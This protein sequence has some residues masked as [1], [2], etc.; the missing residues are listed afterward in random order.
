MSGLEAIR[1]F[2]EQPGFSFTLED[3]HAALSGE[4]GITLHDIQGYL[5]DS[6]HLFY[7][8]QLNRWIRRN[9]FFQDTEFLI[10]PTPEELKQGILIPGHRFVP[11]YNPDIYPS[12]LELY[13]ASDAAV[14]KQ[15]Y[16]T[17]V[18]ELLKYYTLHG[19]ENFPYL[20]I[21]EDASNEVAFMFGNPD[22]Q[23]VTIRVFSLKEWYKDFKFTQGDYIRVRVKDWSKSRFTITYQEAASIGSSSIEDWVHRFDAAFSQVF[24]NLSLPLDIP[25]QLSYAFFYGDEN[26]RKYPQ[27]SI[28][29]Y[30]SASK[31][32]TISRLGQQRCLWMTGENPADYV[33]ETIPS[34]KKVISSTDGLLRELG[35]PY[36]EEELE[37][38][39]R[40]ALF[41]KDEEL[42]GVLDRCMPDRDVRFSGE[43]QKAD[44]YAQTNNLWEEVC[45]SYN[46][47]ND[48]VTGKLRDKALKLTDEYTAWMYRVNRSLHVSTS[49]PQEDI[50][51]LSQAAAHLS[52]IIARLNN[53]QDLSPQ[54][55]QSIGRSIERLIII[56]RDLMTLIETQV[57]PELYLYRSAQNMGFL[58]L[59]IG[60]MD[61]PTDVWRIIEVPGWI[62]GDK[63][64][65]IFQAAMG[66]GNCHD[67][68]LRYEGKMMRPSGS[69]AEYLK[70]GD[71]L[72]Y[73]YDLQDGWIHKVEVLAVKPAETTLISKCTDGAGACPPEDC[74]GPKG[75]AN[76][77]SLTRELAGSKKFSIIPPDPEAF[78]LQTANQRLKEL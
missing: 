73:R 28:G 37:G 4:P 3:I 52:G 27:S 63:L 35:Y 70:P 12:S 74:G 72:E 69:I 46:L 10:Q 48:Q 6:P 50:L 15:P 24:R 43:V 57:K 62:K 78:T 5:L 29:G 76:L 31:E 47:F 65:P 77:L 56:F 17:Q 58:T 34:S 39:M 36:T 59:R 32:I 13:P 26:L 66:W 1:H 30:L 20:L 45:S 41:N 53:P 60:L 14:P 33:M 64:H 9:V 38:Y 68:S 16:I 67:F 61:L 21:T 2:L 75:Y 23:E 42:N 40:D 71:L 55:E 54:D 18:Q 8:D 22:D 19:L 25:T 44:F 51:E 11:F 7:N 49:S